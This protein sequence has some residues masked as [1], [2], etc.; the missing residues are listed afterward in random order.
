MFSSCYA[1]VKSIE[2]WTKTMLMTNTYIK[3][4]TLI[5]KINLKYINS[6]VK[7]VHSVQLNT[8]SS[9]NSVHN[10]YRLLNDTHLIMISLLSN[11]S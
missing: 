7:S 4:I 8:R 3:K 1:I 6:N 5:S 2:R 10:M 11:R 9:F